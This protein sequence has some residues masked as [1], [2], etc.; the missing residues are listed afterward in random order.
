M[1]GSQKAL[2]IISI[3]MIVW[4][5]ITILFG[6][7]LAAG[8][9]IPGM[10][11]QSID[12]SGTALNASSA[13]L[14]LGVG[15]IVGGAINLLIGFLGLRGA[16]DPKKVGAFFVLCIIGLVLGVAG[17]VL[18]IVNGAFQW[19]NL[20][21]VIIVAICTYLATAIKKQA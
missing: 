15:T 8:S 6:A 2:K 4:A 10:S 7:F 18:N 21:S 16:K 11:D 14:A 9:A 17:I 12:V 5:V 20:V 19:T 1:S 13:A 3:I